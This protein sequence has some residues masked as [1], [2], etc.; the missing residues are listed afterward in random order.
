M[1]Q[2]A[3][4]TATT[5]ETFITTALG[6]DYAEMTP[7][8]AALDYTKAIAAAQAEFEA[9]TNRI[10]LATASAQKRFDPPI[11]KPLLLLRRDLATVSAV[12]YTPQGGTTT[13][14]TSGT[15]YVLEPL[16]AADEGRPYYGIHFAQW[17]WQGP[18]NLARKGSIYVTGFWGWGTT[19]TGFPD[20][21]YWAIHALGACKLWPQIAA[22]RSGG[23]LSFSQQGATQDYGVAPYGYMRKE[24][25]DQV[26][27]AMSTYRRIGI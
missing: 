18:I 8:L 4:P 14:F 7:L 24:W 9:K 2:T 27:D 1:A 20:D 6:A 5:L 13:T 3:Y 26:K 15:D 25:D 11:N 12:A 16:N 23:M 17:K 22:R 19:S 10:F 21:V